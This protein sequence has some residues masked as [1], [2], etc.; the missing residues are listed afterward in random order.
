MRVN[1]RLHGGDLLTLEDEQSL[2]LY[3]ALWALAP[4]RRGALSAAGKLKHAQVSRR[5]ELLDLHESSAVRDALTRF[6]RT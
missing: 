4:G 2:Q 3:E 6:V 1:L 5:A